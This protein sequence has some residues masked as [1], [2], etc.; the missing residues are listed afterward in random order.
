R[1]L[2]AS[3]RLNGSRGFVRDIPG[4][5]GPGDTSILVGERHGRDVRM[6]TLPKASEP[7][8]SRIL[9]TRCF[10]K[11]SAMAMDDQGSK[12]AVRNVA[13]RQTSFFPRHL[14]AASVQAPAMQRTDGH[15]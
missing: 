1:R 8:A 3:S 6:P 5:H 14:T 7:A 2:L 9:L 12:I 13:D 15:S 4:E 11:R 10:P